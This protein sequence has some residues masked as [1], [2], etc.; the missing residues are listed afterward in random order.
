VRSLSEISKGMFG[1]EIKLKTKQIDQMFEMSKARFEQGQATERAKLTAGRAGGGNKW[2]DL[3]AAQQM[4][5]R[6][7]ATTAWSNLSYVDR[8][9]AEKEGGRDA[10]IERQAKYLATGESG[11]GVGGGTVS[12]EDEALINK[13]R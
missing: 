13:Y 2:T 3:T 9:K 10:W 5:A 11:G 4:D 1:E 8:S 6:N 7:K 12:P